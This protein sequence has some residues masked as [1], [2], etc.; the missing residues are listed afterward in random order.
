LRFISEEDYQNEKSSRN[1]QNEQG[2]E[3]FILDLI[4]RVMSNFEFFKI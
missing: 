1:Q 3:Y 4:K 2:K